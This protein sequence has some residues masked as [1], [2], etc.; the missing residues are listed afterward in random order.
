VGDGL[1]GCFWGR[2]VRREG[3]DGGANPA[4]NLCRRRRESLYGRG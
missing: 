2:D 1:D 3:E 4:L